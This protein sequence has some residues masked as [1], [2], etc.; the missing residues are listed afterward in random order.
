MFGRG[1]SENISLEGVPALTD[2]RLGLSLL[3]KV[4]GEI[5]PALPSLVDRSMIQCLQLCVLDTAILVVKRLRSEY[6]LFG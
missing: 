6:A 5:L 4:L 1:S 2:N 3:Q